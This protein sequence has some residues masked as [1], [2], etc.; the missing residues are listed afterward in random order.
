MYS[1]SNVEERFLEFTFIYSST[2]KF[3]SADDVDFVLLETTEKGGAT[4]SNVLEDT[5]AKKIIKNS[6][7]TANP[8]PQGNNGINFK[9]IHF[10]LPSSNSLIRE[11]PTHSNQVKQEKK[12]LSNVIPR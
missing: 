3:F 6:K 1:F 2:L 4:T 7:Y 5:A 10:Q 9:Q 12:K 11:A 8:F